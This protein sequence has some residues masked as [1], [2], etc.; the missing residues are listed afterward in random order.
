MVLTDRSKFFLDEREAEIIKEAVKR[1]DKYLE[2]GESLI[3]VFSFSKL[4]GSA[5]Y[6]EV[7]NTRTGMWKCN[8][9]FWHEKGMGCGHR[10]R[11]K[12]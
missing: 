2:I 3:S 6:E 12:V 10:N 4:I 9:N 7:E 5:D 8:Y 1:G 11:D